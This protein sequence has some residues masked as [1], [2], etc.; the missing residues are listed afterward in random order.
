MLLASWYTTFWLFSVLDR[1]SFMLGLFIGISILFSIASICVRNTGYAEDETIATAKFWSRVFPPLTVLFIVL[2]VLLPTK[3]DAMLIVA[4]GSIG[5]F[6]THNE[7][8]KAIPAE[9]TKWL[10]AELRSATIELNPVLQAKKA[11]LEALPQAEL[12][13]QLMATKDTAK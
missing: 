6:V 4:G 2:Q 11:E 10:R 13:K 1:L 12:V 7:D 9:A 8:A 3:H 5:E